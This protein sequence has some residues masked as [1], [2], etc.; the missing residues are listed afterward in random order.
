MIFN[1]DL[2]DIIEES[3]LTLIIVSYMANSKSPNKELIDFVC[4][5]RERCLLFLTLV[6][7]YSLP[8]D[9]TIFI[10]A[11][12]TL[13]R[14]LL[15]IDY[16]RSLLGLLAIDPPCKSRDLCRDVICI[17]LELVYSYATIE[18]IEWLWSIDSQYADIDEVFIRT[19][20]PR[21][22]VLKLLE[23]YKPELFNQRFIDY[24]YELFQYTGRYIPRQSD[25]LEWLFDRLD[26]PFHKNQVG[27]FS[28]I[29]SL[30][31]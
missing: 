12:Y 29:N 27:E 9:K 13:H 26:V 22:D 1:Y 18:Q 21:L 14:V 24:I 6:S 11:K 23:Q 20:I 5:S 31:N 16:R 10:S 15:A 17:D 8:R 4:E 2:L 30:E 19:K 25:A 7:H 28:D 3:K